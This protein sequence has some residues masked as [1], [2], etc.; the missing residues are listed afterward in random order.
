M[1][2][3]VVSD[4]D[5]FASSGPVMVGVVENVLISVSRER[6]SFVSA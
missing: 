5:S 6:D 4:S 2:H 3:V 1:F